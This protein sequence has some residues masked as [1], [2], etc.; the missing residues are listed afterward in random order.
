M[1]SPLA[2]AFIGL[3]KLHYEFVLILYLLHKRKGPLY[4]TP[5]RLVC[6]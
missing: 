3:D 5:F 1:H 2:D 4:A 6:N